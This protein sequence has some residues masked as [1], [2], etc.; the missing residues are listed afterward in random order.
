MPGICSVM[1]FEG[2]SF[3]LHNI[4]FLVLFPFKGHL[5]KPL[6]TVTESAIILNHLQNVMPTATRVPVWMHVKRATTATISMT[7]AGAQ[8][9]LLYKVLLML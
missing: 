6:L 7:I 3:L 8:V 5:Q 9:S 4:C 2:W 1:S